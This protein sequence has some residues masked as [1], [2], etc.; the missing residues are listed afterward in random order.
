MTEYELFEADERTAVPVQLVLNR[1][2]ATL[3][4]LQT[5]AL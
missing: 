2:V 4:A 1:F 3:L 5:K